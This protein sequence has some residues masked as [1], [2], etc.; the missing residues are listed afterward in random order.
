MRTLLFCSVI[1][2]A[3]AGCNSSATTARANGPTSQAQLDIDRVS[4]P[5]EGRGD[6]ITVDGDTNRLYVTHSGRVHI[7]DLG[8]LKPLAE[9]TGLKMAHGVA[10][11]GRN[12]HAF[13]T[14]GDQNSVIM[15]DPASG[16]TLKT[17]PA[18]KKPDAILLERASGKIWAFN[19]ESQSVTVIDPR[20]G[21]VVNTIELP[22]SPESPQSDGGGKVWVTM[23]DA[24][25]IAEIDT[26]TM[27][28]VRTIPLAGCEGP[29]P[30]A[31]DPANR[32]LFSGCG[33]K[34]MMVT[35]ADTGKT[36]TS[37][38][39][40]GAPDGIVFDPE[41]KRLFVANRDGGWTIIDQQGKDRYSVNQTL[42]IDEY[43]KTVALDPAT[44]RI[45]SSTAD[46]V[47]PKPTPGKKLL[48]NAKP[49]TFRLMVVKQG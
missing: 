29:A 40:G 5:G 8:S 1:A 39:I 17:I 46:L 22:S 11:D 41:K 28:V 26:R 27:K 35:E 13:V 43:A 20:T 12:G 45:F 32:L 24:D 15:F 25:A 44:H 34:V 21:D 37:V 16:R 36:L 33:N 42:K 30:L 49:G 7:L 9:V 23:E 47:W 4:L 10:V 19:G 6:F 3:I 2:M 38:P 18:G 14:D 48:P 31:L